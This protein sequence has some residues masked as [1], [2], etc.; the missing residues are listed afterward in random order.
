MSAEPR[1][2]EALFYLAEL[3]LRLQQ[4]RK[5]QETYLRVVQIQTGHKTALYNLGVLYYRFGDY[6][7]AVIALRRALQSDPANADVANL[8]GLAEE[9]VRLS[10]AL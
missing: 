4:Y 9:R 1:N 10:D 7:K 6:D 8:L 5:A 3:Y 2:P